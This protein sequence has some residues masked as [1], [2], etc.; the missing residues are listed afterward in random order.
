M[1][2][3]SVEKKGL[4]VIV[5]ICVKDKATNRA[6]LLDWEDYAKDQPQVD[7]PVIHHI[8][9]GMYGREITIRKDTTLTGQIYKFDHFDIMIS[10]DI[11]VSTE[12]TEPVRLTGFN[13]FK[14]LSGKK[15]AGYAHED[16]RWITFHP[17]DGINGEQIQEEITADSFEE[18]ELFYIDVNRNDY[19]NLVESI[20]M[21]QEQITKQVENTNDMTDFPAGYEHLYTSKSN[22]HGN[23]F[24]SKDKIFNGDV[25]ASA[26][27][28]DMRTNAG[29]YC[30]HAYF[31]NAKII[32]TDKGA[33][34][35]ATK[36]IEASEEITVN[37][38]Q[39][40]HHRL[41]KG[42]VCQE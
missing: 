12:G 21:T 36:D 37:Y 3:L 18:L 1:N 10:G 24:F 17:F 26:R 16:T 7:I 34:L 25:I 9:G 6:A 8:H 28:K 33:D 22:I 42:D 13:I 20:D 2:A 31:Y 4:A 11:T 38:R 5:D 15:R 32:V 19:F 41:L 14:G 40:L 30:N 29:R 27:I 35:I 39:V 23:G